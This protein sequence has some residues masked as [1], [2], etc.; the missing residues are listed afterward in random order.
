MGANN[1][2]NESFILKSKN[3]NIDKILD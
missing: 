1:N 2:K 3:D